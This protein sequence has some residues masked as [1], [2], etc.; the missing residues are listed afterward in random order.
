MEQ[1]S[2]EYQVDNLKMQGYYARQTPTKPQP[3]VIVVH[4]WSGNR[5]YAQ[6]K[7]RYFAE[8]GYLGFAVDLYGKDKRGSY[9]NRALN[10]HLFGELL[11]DRRVIVPRLQA[12]L[13]CAI[14]LGN[15]DTSRILAIGF[16]M[17]GLSVLDLARSGANILAVISVYGIFTPPNYQSNNKITA[18]V[19]AL[20]GYDDPSATPKSMMEFAT[21]MTARKVDWQ[22][23]VFGNTMHAFT[24]PEAHDPNVGAVYNPTNDKRTW[25]IVDNFVKE[26]FS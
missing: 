14:S 16:S 13:N 1:T 19:L 24:N 18:K 3:L 23:H 11:H 20:H 4:D 9:Q 21:E 17:G 15:V 7:A 12:G 26:V 8:Q 10:Q 25:E 5:E 22:L 6:E 2:I